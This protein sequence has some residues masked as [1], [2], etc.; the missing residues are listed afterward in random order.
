MGILLFFA[1]FA[2]IEAI[3]L[4]ITGFLKVS[5]MIKLVKMKFGADSSDEKAVKIMYIS[6]LCLLVLSAVLFYFA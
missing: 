3:I 6:G 4:I 1:W 2:L 5:F